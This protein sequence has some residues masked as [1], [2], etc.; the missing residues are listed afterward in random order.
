MCAASRLLRRGLTLVGL[1]K[2]LEECAHL[3]LLGLHLKLKASCHF[4]HLVL[5]VFVTGG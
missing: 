1:V 3:G 2:L 5:E 4:R